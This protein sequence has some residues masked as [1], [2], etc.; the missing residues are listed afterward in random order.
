I[1]PEI[2][3]SPTEMGFEDLT[4]VHTAWDAKWIKHDVHG[5]AIGEVW[6]VLLRQDATNHTL[7]AVATGHLVADLQLA[8]DGDVHLYHL[9]NA[10]RQLVALTQAID[11]F[12]E[13]LF[14]AAHQLFQVVEQLSDLVHVAR[15]SNL[16][17]VLPGH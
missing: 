3:R 15:H 11:L 7:I 16:T 8:L 5:S 14:T 6:Q 1:E 13:V 2:A 12:S 9:D 17:P 4:H 10:W